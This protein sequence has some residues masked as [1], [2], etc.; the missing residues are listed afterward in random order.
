MAD[1]DDD[2]QLELAIKMSLQDADILSNDFELK[3]ASSVSN[4]VVDLA[5]DEDDTFGLAAKEWSQTQ[6]GPGSQGAYPL[7]LAQEQPNLKS[8]GHNRTQADSNGLLGLDRKAMEEERLSRL[9]RKASISPPPRRQAKKSL[10]NAEASS[11]DH[12]KHT[13]VKAAEEPDSIRS[14]EKDTVPPISTAALQQSS[15]VSGLTYPQGIVRKTWAFG[16]E[17]SNDIKIEEVLRKTELVSAMLSS[18]QWDMDWLLRKVDMAKTKL[19]FVMQAKDDATRRQY[20]KDTATMPNMRLCFPPMDGQ[21]FCMHSKLM[22]LSYPMFLR[23]V[24]PTANLVPFDWGETGVMENMVFLVDLPRLPDGDR[25][26][27]EQLTQFGQ[28]L[29]YFLRAMGLEESMVNSIFGFDFSATK[30]TAFVHTIGGAHSGT[31]ESWRRTGYCGLGRA[32]SNLGLQNDAALNIDYVTSSLGALDLGHLARLYLA[33][34][35]DDGLTE[36]TW[37]NKTSSNTRNVKHKRLGSERQGEVENC[38]RETFHVYFPTDDTVKSSKGGPASGG[39][40]CF[41]PGRYNA[42]AFPRE[43]LRDC[44]SSRNGL[45]MHNK[46]RVSK[47]EYCWEC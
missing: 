13:I 14:H 9:K 40:I 21:I 11:N 6:E 29:V 44:K 19:T 15:Y 20:K 37:R 5:E 39:T 42:T 46:V 32:V 41:H 28:D 45:L 22:L 4:Q 10:V 8:H 31:A 1:Y 2:E 27:T 26:T 23:V 17:R 47:F 43:Q 36:Y 3:Q 30:D 38:I 18:F 34:Q 24:V 33:S 12:P 7:T 16:H 35:G 25:I